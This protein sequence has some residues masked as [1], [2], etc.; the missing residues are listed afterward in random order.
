VNQASIAGEVYKSG[1]YPIAD[2]GFTIRNLILAAGGMTDKASMDKIE[3]VRYEIINGVRERKVL[4]VTPAIAMSEPSVAL[5]PYDEVTV[6][7]IPQW[8]ERKSIKLVGKVKYPG[9]YAIEEGDKLSDVLGR[10][11][12]LSALAY[13]QGAVFTREDLK[14][15]QTEGMERQIKDL[16]NRIIYQA[17]QPVTAGQTSADKMQLVSLIGTLKEDI[18]NSKPVGRLAIKLDADMQ[19]FAGSSSDVVLKD[20]DALYV[21]EREDSVMI[22]G[23]VLNPNAIVYQASYSVNDYIEKAGGLKESGDDDNIFVVHANGEAEM[24]KSGLFAS[25]VAIGPGDVIVVPMHIST[26]SGMQFAKDITA[27]LYQLA[28]SVA[29]LHTVGAL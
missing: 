9:E 6:F 8:N 3:I 27:I 16:E 29:A 22:Q 19:K 18:N 28:V 10:A 26:Y 14:K 2:S 11:G 5:L 13:S 17:T 15:R 21:P 7:K 24:Y 23:E 20:G 4:S 12:G 1:T 25:N